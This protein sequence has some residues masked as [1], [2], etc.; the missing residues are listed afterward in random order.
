MANKSLQR[1]PYMRHVSCLRSCP[2]AFQVSLSSGVGQLQKHFTVNERPVPSRFGQI[3]TYPAATSFVRLNSISDSLRF[4]RGAA[5]S[6]LSVPLPHLDRFAVFRGHRKV[7]VFRRHLPP[8]ARHSVFRIHRPSRLLQTT[9]QLSLQNQPPII[10][11]KPATFFD[12]LS[13]G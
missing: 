4:V 5:R 8:S 1:T 11:S 2:A 6:I 12:G 13:V 9:C 10:E 7:L 3:D